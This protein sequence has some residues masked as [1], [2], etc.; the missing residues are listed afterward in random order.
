MQFA[1]SKYVFGFGFVFVLTHK[2]INFEYVPPFQVVF[3]IIKKKVIHEVENY[4]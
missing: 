1:C 2:K 3:N 4:Q